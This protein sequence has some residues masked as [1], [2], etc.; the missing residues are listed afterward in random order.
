MKK[1]NILLASAS[2]LAIIWILLI[3]WFA[4]AAIINYSQG[5]EP[6]Y[7][8]THSQYL[9]VH[10]KSFNI[11]LKELFISGDINM[12]ITFK[13]GKEL[14][15]LS[16]P[17]KWDCVYSDLHNGKSMISFKN[18]YDHSYNDPVIIMIPEI[19]LLSIDNFGY[20]LINGMVRKQMQLKGTHLLGFCADSCK[21]STLNLD[22]PL[23]NDHSE[24]RINKS[25]H[26]DTLIMSILG[27]GKIKLE[28][29]GT[30]NKFSLSDYV[31]VDATYGFMKELHLESQIKQK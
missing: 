2:V 19:P 7:A 8:H 1:S 11:P 28:T 9:Q 20:V 10:K 29:I 23:N 16:D 17:R 22:F 26:V 25:N 12:N 5:K 18:R 27:S 14:T 6:I 31:D 30:K 4:S 24:I 13:P 15:V 3:G 21:L